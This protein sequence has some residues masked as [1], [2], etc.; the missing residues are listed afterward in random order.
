M[1]FPLFPGHQAHWRLLSHPW[2]LFLR[3]QSVHTWGRGLHEQG[4][5]MV[6][7][8]LK[9]AFLV[10]ICSSLIGCIVRVVS[11]SACSLSVDGSAIWTRHYSQGFHTD[12]QFGSMPAHEPGCL[13][14]PILYWYVPYGRLYHLFIS[15]PF[16]MQLPAYFTSWLVYV[17]LKTLIFGPT[18]LPT[19]VLLHLWSWS[20]CIDVSLCI[21][22][23]QHISNSNYMASTL[24]PHFS[25]VHA[26]DRPNGF[27]PAFVPLRMFLTALVGRPGTQITMAEGLI[28]LFKLLSLLDQCSEHSVILD[29]PK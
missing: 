22:L 24:D 26:G 18:M 16:D 9:C 21:G 25:S 4:W 15:D 7:L 1:L 14:Y 8:G 10:L 23:H 13:M 3:F 19:Q 6:S 11:T 5:W 12:V 20:T 28:T 29:P 17:S 2:T 27:M